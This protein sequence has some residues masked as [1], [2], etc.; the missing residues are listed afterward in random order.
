MKSDAKERRLSG[1]ILFHRQGDG[2]QFTSE[3]VGH[4]MKEHSKR[5]FQTIYENV[6]NPVPN[7]VNVIEY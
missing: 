7:T 1:L 3:G 5:K 6:I 4:V 2:I